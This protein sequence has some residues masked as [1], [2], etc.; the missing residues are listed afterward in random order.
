MGRISEHVGRELSWMRA[1][2]PAIGYELRDGESVVAT[3]RVEGS[4]ASS[5]AGTSDDGEWR[6]SRTGL[7][8]NNV[9]V[10]DATGKRK[11]AKFK[12]SATGRGGVLEISGGERLSVRVDLDIAKYELATSKGAAIVSMRVAG[13]ARQLTGQVEIHAAAKEMPELPWIPLFLWCLS[14]MQHIDVAFAAPAV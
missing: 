6:L 8:R 9:A 11:L 13:H 1:S 2:D 10:T 7:L 4:L 14:V 5:A 3:L 12:K